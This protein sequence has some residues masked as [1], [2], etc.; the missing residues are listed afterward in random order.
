MGALFLDQQNQHK[1]IKT[2]KDGLIQWKD[3]YVLPHTCPAWNLCHAIMTRLMEDCMDI[4]SLVDQ[5]T[6]YKDQ[7][8]QRFQKLYNITPVYRELGVEGPP[9]SRMF[10]MGVCAPDGSILSRGKANSKKK[11]E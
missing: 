3:G 9:H 7:L 11:A 5:D 4:D 10:L 6:N 2:E 8:L 1:D